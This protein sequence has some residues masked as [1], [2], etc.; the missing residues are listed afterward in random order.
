MVLIRQP[1]VAGSFYPA[2][3]EQLQEM[4][5][6]YLDKAQP[7]TKAPKAIIV[8]H[9]GYIYSGEIA[10]SAYARLKAGVDKIKRVVVLGP[11]H[12]VGFKGLAVSHAEFFNTPLGKIPLDMEAIEKLLT[13][14]FV[15]YIDEA[16]HL[17]HSLEVQLP[18]LQTVLK[19]FKL[20][21]IVAGDASAEQVSQVL[22]TFY[23]DAETV[24]VISSDLS[25]YYDYTTAQRMDKETSDK[26]EHL[27][28]Q[29]LDYESACGR[30]PVSGLL[31]LAQK[32]SLHIKNIDLRNSGDTAGDKR[33]V[34]GYGAYV[35]D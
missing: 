28:Y 22:E 16:H 18:F 6:T 4:L 1:A 20:I 23:D 5:N 3:P 19:E 24:I 10:A 12:R 25:H 9:A 14:P 13:L 30:V 11:S 2:N 21:P 26:I 29:Q 32:K 27:Q 15:Q 35:I 33:R 7:T 8:P 17:E 34:V 31:A